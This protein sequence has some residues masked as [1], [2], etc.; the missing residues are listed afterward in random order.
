[1]RANKIAVLVFIQIVIFPT[2][3]AWNYDFS[4]ISLKLEVPLNLSGSPVE[5]GQ[6][7]STRVQGTLVCCQPQENECSLKVKGSIS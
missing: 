5:S 7:K 3:D 2:I 4:K 6:V 1:M